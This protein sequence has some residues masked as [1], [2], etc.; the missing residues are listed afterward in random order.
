[1]YRQNDKVLFVHAGGAKT[2]TSALQNFLEMEKHQLH[3]LGYSYEN[4]PAMVSAYEITSGNGELLY[5][6]LCGTEPTDGDIGRV[7][8]SYFNG[9]R[10]AICSSESFQD[11]D[12]RSWG[13]F[14]QIARNVGVHIELI[15]Y[16]RDV[17]PFLQSVYDQMIKRHGEYRPFAI[18]SSNATWDHGTALRKIVAQVPPQRIHAL[19]YEGRRKSL[20]ES[21][22]S[23]IGIEAVF[24]IEPFFKNTKINRSLTKQEREA[25]KFANS[26]LSE[27]HSRELSDLLIY[28]NP[29]AKSEPVFISKRMSKLLLNRFGPDVRWVNQTFFNSREVVSLLPVEDL[30]GREK[31][32]VRRWNPGER[33]IADKLSYIWAINKLGSIKAETERMTID[34]LNARVIRHWG[35]EHP[36]LPPDFNVLVYLTRNP[37][38]LFSGVDPVQHYLVNGRSEGRSY[39]FDSTGNKETKD[40]V[41]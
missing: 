13:R 4:S 41:P 38:I 3:K 11:L 27:T 19:H 10:K 36:D 18:W 6:K 14:A 16:V 23:I 29:N 12:L 22:L 35:Q 32:P 33:N 8:L 15:F 1:M 26:L 24:K 25:I 40:S 37:D 9:T 30:R 39:S 2:G 17:I 20:I 34:K 28:A 5:A 31:R 7:I 21:F